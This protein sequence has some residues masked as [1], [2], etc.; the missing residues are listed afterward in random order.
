MKAKRIG[1][2]IGLVAIAAL[3]GWILGQGNSGETVAATV[4]PT[5]HS[6]GSLVDSKGEV[7]AL[8][9]QQEP[10]VV[11]TPVVLEE[12]GM[13]VEQIAR[14][15]F[16]SIVGTWSNSAGHLLTF[17]ADGLVSGGGEIAGLELSEYGTVT[18]HYIL[19]PIG[20]GAVEFIPTGVVLQDLTYEKDGELITV[21]E[22]SN[23]QVDRIWL[24]Q[25]I[26]ML[27]DATSFYYRVE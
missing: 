16:S 10:A 24:G 5:M 18:G 25:D 7:P 13:Q 23:S 19:K 1:T 20:G 22:A 3:S 12:A 11:Q 15:D 27:S 6:T 2:G 9:D 4:P 17:S 21:S 14:G 8:V 26:T